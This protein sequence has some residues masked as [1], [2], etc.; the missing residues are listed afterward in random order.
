MDLHKIFKKIIVNKSNNLVDLLKFNKNDFFNSTIY[1]L[2]KKEYKQNVSIEDSEI[3]DIFESI[4]KN[5]FNAE[6]YCNG[7]SNSTIYNDDS[8]NYLIAKS[9]FDVFCDLEKH[10]TYSGI[11]L[12]S[13]IEFGRQDIYFYLVKTYNFTPN[14]SMI[15]YA[16]SN[17]LY[18][19]FIDIEKTVEIDIN[20]M[21]TAFKNSSTK[22]SKWLIDKFNKIYKNETINYLFLTSNLELLEY[23]ETK[24]LLKL[25]NEFYFSAV[26]SGNLQMV[27]FFEKKLPNIHNNLLLD[28][29]KTNKKTLIHSEYSYQQNNKFYNSN[30]MNYSVLSENIDMIDYHLKKGYQVTLSNIVNAIKRGNITVLKFLLSKNYETLDESIYSY[31][32]TNSFIKNKMDILYLIKNRIFSKKKNIKN[33]IVSNFHNSNA[34]HNGQV[35]EHN[36]YDLDF[37]LN[38]SVFLPMDKQDI[39]MRLLLYSNETP[40]EQHIT[41]CIDVF[42]YFC[43][44]SH[45]KMIKVCP[46][47]QVILETYS[48][49]NKLKLLRLVQANLLTDEYIQKIWEYIQIIGDIGIYEIFKIKYKLS[50][51]I[52]FCCHS[53]NKKIILDCSNSIPLN[54]TTLKIIKNMDDTEINTKFLKYL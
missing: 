44:N 12:Y 18:D 41:N 36:T 54:D 19:I 53:K 24:N 40:D 20:I 42:Y 34:T 43:N 49:G 21:E 3:I 17:D 38:R 31:F 45:L 23:L 6:I 25:K 33:K 35:L 22:I 37:L 13:S 2:I 39:I 32:G 26:L 16:V 7:Y 1:E 4:L 15:K 29:P 30:I 10:F 14:Y 52:N 5:K 11:D 47:L 8:K 9:R 28:T 50:P 46:K 48:E 51:D 27:K